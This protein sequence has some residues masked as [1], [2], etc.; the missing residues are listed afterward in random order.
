MDLLIYL[1]QLIFTDIKS[2]H[3]DIGGECDDRSTF[4][5]GSFSTT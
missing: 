2:N 5:T 3:T 4:Y 1:I